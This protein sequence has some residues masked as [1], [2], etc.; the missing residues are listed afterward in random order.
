MGSIE[1]EL[2]A[3]QKDVDEMEEL[4]LTNTMGMSKDARVEP[5]RRTRPRAGAAEAPPM[6]AAD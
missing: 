6:S 2:K 5:S 4:A 1:E 3:A